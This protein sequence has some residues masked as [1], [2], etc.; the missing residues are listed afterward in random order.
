[1]AQNVPPFTAALD[2]IPDS[3]VDHGLPFVV[4]G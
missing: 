3:F 2:S 1:M 4:L